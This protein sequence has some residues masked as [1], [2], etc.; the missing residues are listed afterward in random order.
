MMEDPTMVR[1][2]DNPSARALLDRANRVVALQEE[3]AR[4]AR[5]VQARA[6]RAYQAE[7]EG[8]AEEI[9]FEP[10]RLLAR[11]VTVV[12]ALLAITA[13]TLGLNLALWTALAASLIGMG[14]WA[15]EDGP[16]GDE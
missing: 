5:R 15:T 12:G 1:G 3:L 13:V 9:T 11:A 7:K 10:T 16:W 14:L 8:R 4:S 6:E 2:T